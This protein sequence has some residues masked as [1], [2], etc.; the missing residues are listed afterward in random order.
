MGRQNLVVPKLEGSVESHLVICTSKT[1]HHPW[2][3]AQHCITRE[4]ISETSI[5]VVRIKA[6]LEKYAMPVKGCFQSLSL[7]HNKS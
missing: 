7:L 5:L 1:V 2:L 4:K 3:I 6:A